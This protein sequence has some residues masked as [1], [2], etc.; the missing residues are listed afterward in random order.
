MHHSD[1]PTAAPVDFNRHK[2]Y[3]YIVELSI[4]VNMAAVA[5]L[6]RDWL[7]VGAAPPTLASPVEVVKVSDDD[8]HRQRY[9][10]NTGN[11]AQSADE[12]PPDADRRDVTVA[13]GRHRH[14]C[15]PES[16]RDRRD[17]RSLFA[18]F[19]VVRHRAEDDHGDE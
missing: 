6:S 12:F 11:D 7:L 16:A 8:G 1:R 18:H 10:Q 13:D 2:I 14:D 5:Y 4:V 3:A 9:C 19:G 17:L 15:P